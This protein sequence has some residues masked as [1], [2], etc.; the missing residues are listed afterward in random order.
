MLND[1]GLRFG[2]L[3]GDGCGVYLYSYPCHDRFTEFD[4]WVL[5]EVNVVGHL[6]KLRTGSRGRYILKAPKGAYTVAAEGGSLQWLGSSP[7]SN[8][9][10][11]V[12]L[13]AVHCLW[14]SLPPCVQEA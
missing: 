5:L 9:S 4:P 8:I 13:V 1:R 12:E 11:L 3:H 10:E 6:T 2:E 7:E 14:R